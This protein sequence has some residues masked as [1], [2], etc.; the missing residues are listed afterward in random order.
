ML[1]AV[2]AAEKLTLHVE[3][4]TLLVLTCRSCVG[5][6]KLG[7]VTQDNQKLNLF[8]MAQL[9]NNTAFVDNLNELDIVVARSRSKPFYE[10]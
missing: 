6:C 9:K 4:S 8:G 10:N 3:R 1:G 2:S 7:S 5:R